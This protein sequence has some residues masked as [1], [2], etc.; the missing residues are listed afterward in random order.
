MKKRA[1]AA[2]LACAL[3]A[4]A[5][6]G[7]APAPE[8][9]PGYD[10][11][12][13][14]VSGGEQPSVGVGGV[15]F[16]ALVFETG[17]LTLPYRQYVPADYDETKSYPLL[18]FLHG[19]GERGEDNTKPVTAYDGLDSLF[20]EADDPARQAIVLV[21]QCPY[22]QMWVEIGGAEEGQYSVEEVAESPAMTAVL[23]LVKY[24]AAD[25][26]VDTGRIY[27][28]G[29]SMGGYGTWDILA[30]HSELLAAAV[31]I[32]G[33]CDVSAA[34]RIKDIPIRTFHGALDPIVTPEGTRAMAEALEGAGAADFS[35]T[36]YADGMHDVWNR[37]MQTEGL[38][39]WLFAQRR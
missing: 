21:P 11:E 4:C 7:C 39:D 24:T 1:I 17:D 26:S 30:R 9:L 34:E 38:D 37:A 35:Y 29:M 20:D 2:A 31:P 18:L 12:G 33:G 25:Y 22:G 16:E 32:C 15:D 6:A 23:Q 28:M 3:A 5:F 10:V 8:L 36:E 14:T 19:A 13:C 27:A